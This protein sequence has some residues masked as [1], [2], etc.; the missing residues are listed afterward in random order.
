MS[1]VIQ[2]AEAVTAELNA[3]ELSQTVTAERHYVPLFELPEMNELHVTVVP[4]GVQIENADRTRALHDVQIDIAVQKKFETGDLTEIDPLLALVEE[5]AEWFRL[6]RLASFPNARWIKTEHK[7][8]YAQDHWE[9]FRQ[10]TSV[11][12]LTFRVVL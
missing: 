3:A 4:R 12:V 8:L 2:V 10:F 5:I 7:P 6:H 11:L 1:M 9:E